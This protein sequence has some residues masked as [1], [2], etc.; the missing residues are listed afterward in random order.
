MKKTF[1]KKIGCLLVVALVLQAFAAAFI[2]CSTHIEDLILP[3]EIPPADVDVDIDVEFKTLILGY[4][5]PTNTAT[6]AGLGDGATYIWSI[7]GDSNHPALN[8]HGATC[9]LIV[10]NLSVG[11]HTLLVIGTLDGVEYS[12]DCIITIT[13]E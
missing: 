8:A 3:K 10:E 6:A 7:D 2:S 12:A 11:K 9:R 5:S 13:K 4:D 1:T